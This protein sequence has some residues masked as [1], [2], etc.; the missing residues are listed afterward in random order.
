MTRHHTPHPYPHSRRTPVAAAV[1][2]WLF[3]MIVLSGPA[4]SRDAGAILRIPDLQADLQGEPAAI[5]VFD[6]SWRVRR[7][8]WKVPARV[9]VTRTR[10][11]ASGPGVLRLVVRMDDASSVLKQAEAEG[12]RWPTLLL[13]VPAGPPGQLD[14]TIKLEGVGVVSIGPGPDGAATRSVALRFERIARD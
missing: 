12:R 2:G 3:A 11:P 1:G 8:A 6:W 7:E 4:H 10:P 13:Q 5:E 14:E 9:M